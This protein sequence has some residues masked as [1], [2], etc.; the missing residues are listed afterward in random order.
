MLCKQGKEE[1]EEEHRHKR[2]RILKASL[3][4]RKKHG[5]IEA[6]GRS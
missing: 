3:K 4:E 1:E 6:H 2:K 5:R